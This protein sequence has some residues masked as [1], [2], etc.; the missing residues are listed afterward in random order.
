MRAVKGLSMEKWMCWASMGVAGFLLLLF[1]LDLVVRFP[2]GGL[3]RLVDVLA[4]ISCGV[5][6]YLGWDAFQDLR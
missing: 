5:V 4:V 2:F 3:N 6:L 1:L